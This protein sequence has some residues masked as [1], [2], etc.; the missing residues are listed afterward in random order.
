M[1]RANADE[2]I[3]AYEHAGSIKAV[4]RL[5]GVS[6][7]VVRRTLCTAGIYASN[8][9]EEINELFQANK[10]I[11]EI[12]ELLGISEKAVRMNLPYTRGS[13]STT[14][15]TANANRIKSCREQKS[16]NKK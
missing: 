5:L 6:R 13:Y 3:A 1:K 7:T 11:K 15:P 4:V 2:I 12:S 8:Y 16:K 10:S 14:P 9:I